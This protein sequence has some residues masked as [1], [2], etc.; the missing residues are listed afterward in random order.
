MLQKFKNLSI[1]AKELIA[2][3][4]VAIIVI[5][6]AFKIQHTDFD[7]LDGS[8]SLTADNPDFEIRE[9]TFTDELGYLD[10]L[11]IVTNHSDSTVDFDCNTNAYEENETLIGTNYNRI[12]T[13]EPGN[14]GCMEFN[15][16]FD[17]ADHFVYDLYYE[18]SSA[19]SAT[20]D[21]ETDETISG[22]H[23][24]AACTN[25]GTE[26]LQYLRADVLF[27]KD[28]ELVDYSTSYLY[29]E[30]GNTLSPGGTISHTFDSREE[31]D[32]YEIYYSCSRE[33]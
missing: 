9:Y 18:T 16:Q 3:L 32:D 29:E 26:N 4:I 15:F 24:T 22:N 12:N 21:L 10:Y 31:F 13:I 30:G 6:V 8:V 14:S 7:E 20:E 1:E 17:Y 25:T 27:F 33:E 19:I 2:F 23:V 5:L 28:G 11:L